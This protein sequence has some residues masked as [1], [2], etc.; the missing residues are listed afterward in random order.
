MMPWGGNENMPLFSCCFH[1]R[2]TYGDADLLT[3]EMYGGGVGTGERNF[4]RAC[5]KLLVHLGCAIV[6]KCFHDHCCIF[7][8]KAE[9]PD[10]VGTYD[11]TP[12]NF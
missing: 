2:V 4:C 5:L 6:F 11:V 10:D 3:G 7:S 9:E 1:C 12:P 8:D